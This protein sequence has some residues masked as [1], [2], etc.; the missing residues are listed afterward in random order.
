LLVAG[1]VALDGIGTARRRVRRQLRVAWPG[2]SV[3]AA[4]ILAS[5][6]WEA[7]YGPNTAIAYRAIRLALSRA[8]DQYWRGVRDF[9]AGFGYLEFRL[10]LV[11]YLLWIGFVVLLALAAFRVGGRRE[12][13]SVI[14]AGALTVVVPV[15]VWIVFGRAAGIGIIGREYMPVLVAFPLLAGEVVYRHRA[16][17]S[18]RFAGVLMT[19]AST[20][21]ILH[22]LAWYL[23]G[24]RAAVGTAGHLLFPADARWS[25]PLGWAGWI[26]VAACGALIL[27]A[28]SVSSLP[29]RPDHSAGERDGSQL[30]HILTGAGA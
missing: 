15:G 28:A 20:A 3:F 18:T 27:A 7:L 14:A 21:G 11:V 22:F 9:I 2:L 1:F 25:P 24:R 30:D 26:T 4:G 23:N 12:R 17:L 6:A 13:R 16:R 10:P 29:T 19:L 8:P 5:L